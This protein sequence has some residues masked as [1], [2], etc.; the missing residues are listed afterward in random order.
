[1]ALVVRYHAHDANTLRVAT[2]AAALKVDVAFER[3]PIS[4]HLDGTPLL[5][6]EGSPVFGAGPICRHLF[7]SKTQPTDIIGHGDAKEG[8][9]VEEWL[10]TSDVVLDGTVQKYL[11][12]LSSGDKTGFTDSEKA[13]SLGYLARLEGSFSSS[14]GRSV[15]SGL[16]V[17][18]IYVWGGLYAF[19]A[20]GVLVDEERRKYPLIV[21]WFDSVSALPAAKDSLLKLKCRCAASLLAP[22]APKDASSERYYISTAINYTNGNPHIGHAYEAITSDMIA[23]WHRAYGRTVFYQTGTDEHGQKIAQTAELS[24]ITPQEICD[25]YA[26]AFQALNSKL[27]ISNDFYIRTTMPMHKKGAQALFVKAVEAGDIYLD[28]YEGWYNVREE[29][30]VTE[31]EAA[32]NDYKDPSSGK[33]LEKMTEVGCA[34]PIAGSKAEGLRDAAGLRCSSLS[35]SLTHSKVAAAG[36]RIRVSGCPGPAMQLATKRRK[37]QLAVACA[38]P[39]PLYFRAE[40]CDA[41]PLEG[42][43][44]RR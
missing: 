9:L 6:V 3:V 16:S 28:T 31:N 40:L 18:D 4:T 32:Q 1:M 22:T 34:P 2:I 21:E 15:L 36:R 10:E 14:K 26:G 19:F 8:S 44:C 7:L 41:T 12:G 17:V 42:S 23:R 24:G 13:E 37:P 5:E 43:R 20:G 11:I 29:T 33:P 35:L 25:K 30:F 39:T 38:L 27:S